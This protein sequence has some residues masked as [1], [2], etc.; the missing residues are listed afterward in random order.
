MPMEILEEIVRQCDDDLALVKLA[1]TCHRMKKA[2]AAN[3]KQ[4]QTRYRQRFSLNDS[5]ELQW[6]RMYARARA[7]AHRKRVKEAHYQ[8]GHATKGRPSAYQIDW[9]DAFCQRGATESR[10]RQ[11]NF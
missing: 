5:R 2:V 8:K 10:W 6:L 3:D 11:G 7:L 9:F 4:W 1:A